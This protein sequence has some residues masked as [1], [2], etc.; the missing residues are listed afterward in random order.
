MRDDVLI[1]LNEH[2]S[3]KRQRAEALQAALE[4]KLAVHRIETAD[5][6]LPELVAQRN[7]RVLILDYILGEYGTVVDLL[8]ACAAA[9]L[10]VETIVWTD[11][12]SAQ[13]AVS[14]MK[15][16]AHD[17]VNIDGPRA[18]EKVLEAIFECLSPEALTAQEDRQHGESKKRQSL[19]FESPIAKSCLAEANAAAASSLPILVLL[20]PSGSG[21]NALARHIHMERSFAGAFHEID[22]DL[23]TGPEEEILGGGTSEYLLSHAATVLLDHVESG[24]GE[25]VD[26]TARRQDALWSASNDGSSPVLIIGTDSE[27]H[28]N[29][30]QRLVDAKVIRI[31][32]LA[33]RE[34]DVYPLLQLFISTLPKSGK[35]AALTPTPALIELIGSLQ[36]PGNIRELKAAVIEAAALERKSNAK[37]ECP[38]GIEGSEFK[39]LNSCE[40]SFLAL[41]IENKA[42]WERYQLRRDHKVAALQARKVLLKAGG[43]PR[44]AAAMLGTSVHR[45]TQA[46]SERAHNKNPQDSNG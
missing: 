41:L 15:L 33:E 7:P 12:P 1:I 39:K 27:E 42:R 19:V 25:F 44:R 21:R 40:Q 16:G 3:R 28:A 13:V 9:E 38:D 14:V 20:G 43:D 30:W 4:D 6:T 32:A 26:A 22:F 24:L 17:Y 29:A 34:E 10:A 8:H 18:V 37:A 11:E 23:F 46:L 2:E 35:K 45:I 36:W 5:G 31:P